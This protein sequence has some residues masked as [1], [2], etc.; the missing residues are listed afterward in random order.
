MSLLVENPMAIV[1]RKAFPAKD[2]KELI[3]WFK[4]NPG[5][6]S[7]GIAGTGGAGDVVGTFF[8]K[9]TGTSF[10]FVPY[11]GAAPL[12][13]DLIAGQIDLTIAQVAALL[14]QIRGGQVKG[15]AVMARS[16]WSAA[17]D[18]PTMDESGV[19]GLYASLWHGLWVP[20]ATPR[21]V[22]AK[23]NAAVVDALADQ[24]VQQRLAGLGQEIFPRDQQTPEALGALHKAEIE[25]WWPIIKAANIR[26]Q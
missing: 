10:Q 3:T 1:A 23:L 18:V 16:R 13:Q 9:A 5:K 19:S 25:K 7:V 4:Q 20:T 2:T 17:P 24:A 21:E 11:R 15:Y 14:E 6:A 26:A 12:M 22:I 8:Q